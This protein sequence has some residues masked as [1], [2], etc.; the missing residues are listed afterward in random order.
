MLE[1]VSHL[2][3]FTR[4]SAVVA[5]FALALAV[6]GAQDQEPILDASF[7]VASFKR[8][9]NADANVVWRP[10]P[11]GEFTLI[12]IPFT[13]LLYGAYQLQPYQLVG[14]PSWVRDERYDILA[15]L[16]PKIAGR[17]QPD[18]HPPTWALALRRLLVER[19]Q[20]TFHRETRQLPVYALVVARPDRKLGPNIRPAQADCDA[21]RLQSEVAA[22]EGKPSPYPPNTSTYVACGLRNASGRITSGGFGFA[23]F[24]SALSV[25]TGRAV[26]D[27]TGLSGK[28][29]L[30][31]EYAPAPVPPGVAPDANRPD[32]FTALQEQLGLKLEATTGPVQV[33]V[34]DRLER[35]TPD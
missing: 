16:D 18:G 6:A 31:V 19:A 2:V 17:L 9:V 20:L 26:L 13:T 24:L 27:R 11:T 1:R 12:N 3:Q 4:S 30:H 25:Q 10:Q 32:L 15:K 34:V 8:N 33:F 21:L 35:P 28:W 22:R 5:L 14:A 7:D 23:E 29:D